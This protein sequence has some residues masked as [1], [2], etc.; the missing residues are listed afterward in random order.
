MHIKLGKLEKMGFNVKFDRK[1][2]TLDIW[3]NERNDLAHNLVCHLAEELNFTCSET[4]ELFAT[5]SR[6]QTLSAIREASK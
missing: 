6:M 1:E 3:P 5:V 2:N 4:D